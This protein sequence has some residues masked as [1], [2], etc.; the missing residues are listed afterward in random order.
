M[1]VMEI[2]GAMLVYCISVTVQGTV[3]FGANM[4]AVPILALINPDFVPGPVL[5]MNPLMNAIFTIRERGN[6]DR[7]GLTWALIGRT[8]GMLAG[9]LALTIV[10][11]ERL[12]TLFGVLVLLAVGMKVSGLHPTRNRRSLLIAGGLSGF[13]GT[14]VAVGGP[15]IALMYHDVP[16]AVM[17][18]TLSPYFL[19]GTPLAI[20]A[21]AVAGRFGTGDL[22]IAAW[23]V[24]AL[25][26]G[27]AISHPLRGTMDRGWIAPAVYALS[28]AGALTLLIRSLV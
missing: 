17:R 9:V 11:E 21:L 25:L 4:L 19:I 8:P 10:A 6:V 26:V 24:P 13:M 18:A 23:L 20:G 5:L 22:L 16:G 27:A 1:T 28:S 7:F 12:G 15:P 3:G 14:T 2:V